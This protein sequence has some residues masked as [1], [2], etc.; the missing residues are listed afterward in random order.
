M[1][2]QRIELRDGSWA[3]AHTRPSHG[4]MKA[5]YRSFRGK[6]EAE[7]MESQDDLILIL[8]A[9]WSIKGMDLPLTREGIDAA[10]QDT[11]SE[12]TERLSGFLNRDS[13]EPEVVAGN[14]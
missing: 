3:M 14:A 7:L 13:G 10:P 6:A 1:D 4:Q 2:I 9:E 11:V 8:C 12:L 5:F